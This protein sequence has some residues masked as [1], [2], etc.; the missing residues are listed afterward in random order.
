MNIFSIVLRALSGLVALFYGR[1]FFWLFL[2]LIGF[3][4]GFGIGASLFPEAGA[5]VHILIGLGAG[6]VGAA[7]SRAAPLV[8]AALFGFFAGGTILVNL[9]STIFEPGQ[10]VTILLFVIGG[11]LGAYLL[12]QALDAGIVILSALAGAEV[13]STL[14]SEL[15]AINQTTQLIVALVLFAV[16]LL[17]QFRL[18]QPDKAGR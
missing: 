10:L 18:V 13:L 1:R 17:F 5:L 7:L 16:G 8:I 12:S 14:G 3:I 2:G 15:F 9:A 11:A 4:A 6:I